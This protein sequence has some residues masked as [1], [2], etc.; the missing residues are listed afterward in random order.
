LKAALIIT[1]AVVIDSKDCSKQGQHCFVRLQSKQRYK[2]DGDSVQLNLP[3]ITV[4]DLCIS[5]NERYR[6]SFVTFY[7]SV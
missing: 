1:F 5:T 2:R 3:T 6:R 7:T 4:C